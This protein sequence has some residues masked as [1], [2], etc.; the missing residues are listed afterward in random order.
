AV[1]G[2]NQAGDRTALATLCERLGPMLQLLTSHLGKS[3]AIDERI[4]ALLDRLGSPLV[5]V[6]AGEFLMGDSKRRV[7]LDR[8]WMGKFSVTNALYRKFCA[9]AGRASVPEAADGDHP[10]VLVSWMDAVAF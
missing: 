2:L 9:E 6:P 4:L 7:H 5:E 1:L 8:C 10:V 3:A